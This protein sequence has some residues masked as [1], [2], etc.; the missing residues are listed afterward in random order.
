[1]SLR[2]LEKRLEKEPGNLSLRVT[3]AGLMCE[4]GRTGE[5][6]ELYRSVASAYHDQGRTQQAMAVCRSILELAPGDAACHAL[7]QELANDTAPHEIEL[8]A[9]T[10]PPPSE[11]MRRSSVT[12][13]PR[14]IPYHVAD[15]TIAADRVAPDE[16]DLPTVEGA[17]TRPG[18]E[19]R[20][21]TSSGLAHAARRISGLIACELPAREVDDVDLSAELET[22]QV[23]RISSQELD[24]IS[25]PPPTVPVERVPDPDDDEDAVTPVPAEPWGRLAA[26]PAIPIRDTPREP[27]TDLVSL[28][29]AGDDG[30]ADDDERTQP[31]EL[32]DADPLA[33]AFFVAL[34]AARRDT[35]LARC[36]RRSVRAGTTVIR[37]GE[38]SHPLFMVVS[39]RLE[40]RVERADAT[41]AI[42][43]TIDA[44]QYVGE[45]ALL[46]RAP[47]GVQAIA[48]ADSEL[49]ALPPHALFEL[50]GAYPQRWAALKDTA[51]RR[52]RQLD[53]ASRASP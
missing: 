5:A 11:P 32:A 31:R 35:A 21:G 10:P 30:H 36:L 42:I 27:A 8:E 25:Q 52:T 33:N 15:P 1:M 26:S 39:G 4:A 44:G 34:P 16:L 47:S 6:I 17:Q 49:L 41:L 13:L 20:P 23:P 37:Q 3:A 12:P 14:P 53:R 19:D 38:T 18:D 48:V 46:G 9:G 24:K 40:L 22:R 45:A 2:D 7:L 50:A 28:G 29:P 43:D 51:E